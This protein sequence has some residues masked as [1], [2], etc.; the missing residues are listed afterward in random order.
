[1][2]VPGEG[3]PNVSA[4]QVGVQH[5]AGLGE[6]FLAAFGIVH[7]PREGHQRAD[8]VVAPF[9]VLVDGEFSAHRLDAA[10][11]DNHGFG[12]VC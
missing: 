1:V 2:L 3:V 12:F 7:F 11:Q 4:T 8:L 9:D 5:L 10:R 6:G